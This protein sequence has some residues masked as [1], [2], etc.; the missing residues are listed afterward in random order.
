MR[1][2]PEEPEFG[3]GHV[4]EKAVWDALKNSL[5]DDVV[6]AHSVQLR[7]GRQ[8]TRSTSSSYGPALAWLPLR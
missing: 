4:A 8:N 5:P 2:I 1:C 6:L 7:D 3:D